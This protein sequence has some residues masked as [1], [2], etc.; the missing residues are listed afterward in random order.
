MKKD[1]KERIINA[2]PFGFVGADL[3]ETRK[4]WREKR[5]Q[6]FGTISQNRTA[7]SGIVKLK[8]V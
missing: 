8:S 7:H 5:A 6:L 2:G 1:I 4:N 3:S